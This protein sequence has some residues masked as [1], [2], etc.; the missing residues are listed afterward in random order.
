MKTQIIDITAAGI[1]NKSVTNDSTSNTAVDNFEAET[2][3]SYG[4]A[5]DMAVECRREA[6]MTKP[7][8]VAKRRTVSTVASRAAAFFKQTGWTIEDAAAEAKA[9]MRDRR[10][11]GSSARLY[12]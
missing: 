2:G 3:W 9:S 10:L 8:R 6:S 5:L 1:T 12:A 4:D 7:R 11:F